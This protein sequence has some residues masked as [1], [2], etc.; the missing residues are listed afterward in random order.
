[1]LRAAAG[2]VESSGDDAR[3]AW[4]DFSGALDLGSRFPALGGL[5]VVRHVPRDAVPA[6]LADRRRAGQDFDLRPAHDEPFHLPIVMVAHD[7][8][9]GTMLGYDLAFER[10]RRAAVAR[11]FAHDAV[12]LTAPVRPGRGESSG[13]VMVAPYRGRSLSGDGNA[14]E[15]FAG[16]VATSMLFERLFAGA[17][18]PARREVRLRIDD[19]DETLLDEPGDAS[20]PEID[21]D[22]LVSDE[23]ALAVHGRDWR[24]RIEST[25]AFRATADVGT[26]WIV[27][28]SGLVID[29]LLTALLWLHLRGSH[30]LL[31]A[32]RRLRAERT[33]LEKSN[34]TLEAF[35]SIVS[36]DLKAPLLSIGMLIDAVE[37]DVR[38]A[39]PAHE[40]LHTLARARAKTG[41]ADALVEG[42]LEYSGLGEREATSEPVD[43]GAL[44]ADIG[45]ALDVGEGALSVEGE[46]PTIDTV[47]TR[48]RQV[49]TNLIGN[50]FKYHD[51]PGTA[52]V[53]VRVDRL[54]DRL[55]FSVADD[56]PGIDPRCRDRIFEPFFK[57][58]GTDRADS[59][60]LGLAI[61]AQNV[62]TMGG[63]I[64][65]LPSTG[66]GAT[67]VF[68]WPADRG[69]DDP[70]MEGTPSASAE[71]R[72]SPRR[73][74]AA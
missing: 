8:A 61:V 44:V 70:G 28:G 63:T 6:L 48:L 10:E 67:F 30:H 32:A 9:E 7:L 46:L 15:R 57:A 38:D 1:M 65:L 29:A 49:L 50:A 17:L 53:R 24:L 21:S 41:R 34:R 58:H 62:E 66:R 43:V 52:E 18:D 4:R 55:R 27:L 73:W 31:V 20:D 69:R 12:R 3:D 22:P 2:F 5:A 47:E 40:L 45:E 39:R 35:A 36:H 54:D 42:V 13:A 59:N 71:H 33:A 14:P 56:G 68:T 25:R 64:E 11:A 60:G 51:A 37:D 19:G 74:L 23:R 16:V 72:P 26:P